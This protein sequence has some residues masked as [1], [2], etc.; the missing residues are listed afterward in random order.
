MKFIPGLVSISFREL[1][2]EAL[3]QRAKETG[4]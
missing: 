1:S 4:L 3:I 2:T